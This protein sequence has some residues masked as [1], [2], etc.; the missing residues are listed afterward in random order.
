MV[1]EVEVVITN[2]V[3]VDIRMLMLMLILLFVC[4]LSVSILVS[5]NQVNSSYVEGSILKDLIY[6]CC[7]IVFMIL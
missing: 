6:S 1:D 2:L 4:I 7:M 5:V 3:P